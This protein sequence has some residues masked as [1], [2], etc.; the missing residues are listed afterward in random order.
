MSLF[1]VLLGY[2]PVISYEDNQDLWLKSSAINE[3]AATLRDLM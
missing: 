3:E 2:Y 1:E